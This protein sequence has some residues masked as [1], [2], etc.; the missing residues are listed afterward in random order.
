M[1]S[2]IFQGLSA[3]PLTPL[4]DNHIDET[5]LAKMLAPLSS[6]PLADGEVICIP[7]F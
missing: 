4:R 1:I 2:P 3:F 5:A 6:Q 7:N